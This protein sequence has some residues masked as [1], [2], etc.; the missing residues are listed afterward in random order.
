[1]L[2]T[3]ACNEID[4]FMK[5]NGIL[6][7]DQLGAKFPASDAILHLRGNTLGQETVSLVWSYSCRKSRQVRLEAKL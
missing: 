3:E 4:M 5:T 2:G 1:M 6:V 7:L